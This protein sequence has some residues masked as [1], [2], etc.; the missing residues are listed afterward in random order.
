[1]MKFVFLALLFFIYYIAG[2]YESPALT[3][4]FLT[5]FLLLVSMLPLARYLNR[6]LSV[7]FSETFI[8]AEKDRPYTWRLKADNRG[9]LPVGRFAL[10]ISDG[11]KKRRVYA[12]AAPGES[13]LAFEDTR[14]HCGIFT[15]RADRLKVYDYLSLFSGKQRLHDE[16]RVAVFPVRYAMRLEN[17]DSF[18]SADSHLQSPY[19]AGS[20]S[21]EIRQIREYRDGD[22][23]RYIHWNQTARTGEPW[24][25]EYEE[26][27]NGQYSLYLERRAGQTPA[28]FDA[29]CTLLD[30]LLSALLAAAGPVRVLWREAQYPGI[31]DFYVRDGEQCRELLYLLYQANKFSVPLR[32]SALMGILLAVLVGIS[33]V[34]TSFWGSELSAAVYKGEGFISRS[35]LRLTGRA[36]D[37]NSD[38]HV[39]SG[40]NYRTG[41]QQLEVT[42]PQEPTQ[43]L[44]LKGF[45]GGRYIGGEWEAADDE[46][47]FQEMARD[48]EWERWET[49]ISAI[50]DTL[51]FIM[52]RSSKEDAPEPR[53]LTLEHTNGSYRTLYMPYFS[54][55]VE[56]R[57]TGGYGFH[58]YQEAELDL[59]WEYAYERNSMMTGWMWQVQDAY[60]EEI[61]NAYTEVPVELLPRL[62]QLCRAN[63]ADSLEEAT[64]LILTVLRE[65]ASYTLMP[66]RAPLNEDIVEY[67]LFENHEGYC[68][69]FASAATLMY[70][71]WGI[72]ARYASGYALQPSDFTLQ[73]DGTWKAEVTDAFAHAWTEIFLEDYRWTPVEFTPSADGSFDASYPGL[74]TQA[75]TELLSTVNL[76]AEISGSTNESSDSGT[77]SGQDFGEGF[78][79][80]SGVFSRYRF[81]LPIAGTALV[82]SLLLIP[83]FLDYRRLRR[84]AQAERMNCREVFRRLMD[85]IHFAGFLSGCSGMEE[86]FAARFEKEIPC[87]EPGDA[88]RLVQI[89]SRAAYGRGEP[90][91]EEEAFVKRIYFSTG[92]WLTGELKGFRRFQFRYLKAFF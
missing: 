75:L 53:E 88:Q 19:R 78:P 5:Q 9:K 82:I 18:G 83:L 65:N 58:Y 3:V 45:T 7:C 68:V 16:M 35:A 24:V 14:E 56:R 84:R 26:E 50:Y 34:L 28:A 64:A 13:I 31:R 57:D 90:S 15:I 22:R 41:E 33:A 61:P 87:T 81:L 48:L 21:G 60:I 51:Y 29:Y 73:P 38:G 40:N 63:P 79:D 25:K 62:T 1:M 11:R 42:L 72:P 46:P 39:S 30:A 69:H 43:T 8:R 49:W 44:Y 89:V 10:R 70:R 32:C 37:P 85:M 4:L 52:N 12:S 20:V 23:I 36:A 27:Q 66:G 47:V 74:D 77:E 76:R 17:A 67:F 86:D 71:L 59:D 92:E 2:M 80:L 6:R 55:P 54:G 91:K